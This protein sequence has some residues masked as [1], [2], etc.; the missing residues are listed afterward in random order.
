MSTR[1]FILS[2]I[3]KALLWLAAFLGAY[4]LFRRFVNIDYFD[5]LKPVFDNERLMYILFLVSEI[6]I[7]V[8]PPEIFFIWALRFEE[9]AHFLFVIGSLALI[10]YMAGIIGYFIGRYLNRTLYF[11]YIKIRFLRKMDK[12]L[13]Q[14]GLY[15][16]IV[17]ALTPVPFS[18]VAMLVGS[19]RYPF[20]KY[21][22]FSLTR[23]LRFAIYAWVFWEARLHFV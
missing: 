22:M 20:V 18:G 15:L 12:R 3:L 14:Y 4:L 6:I 19:T 7:G 8:V 1:K 17:A 9:L 5:W 11:R 23:F 13:K 10:S 21:F 2:N 16:I